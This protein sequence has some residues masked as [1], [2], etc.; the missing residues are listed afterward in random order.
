MTTEEV[1]GT[2]LDLALDW[3]RGRPLGLPSDVFRGKPKRAARFLAMI[4]VYVRWCYAA[5]SER[6]R[7]PTVSA[8]AGCD[9]HYRGFWRCRNRDGDCPVG[10]ADLGGELVTVDKYEHPYALEWYRD[11]VYWEMHVL[12]LHFEVPEP[13]ELVQIFKEAS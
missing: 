1:V 9:G 3:F 11:R 6:M 2:E 13:G 4:W 5:G 10:C 7:K 8:C 12:G